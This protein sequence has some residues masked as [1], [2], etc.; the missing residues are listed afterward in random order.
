MT[1]ALRQATRDD[2]E[3]LSTLVAEYFRYDGIEFNATVESGIGELLA[4]PSLG[5][6]WF[7]EA[8]GDVAG[9]AVLTAAFDHEIGGRLGV[10]TDF[11]LSEPLRGKGLGPRFLELVLGKARERGYLAVE[12]VV[13]DDNVRAR[14]IYESAGFRSNPRRVGMMKLLE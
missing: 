12:L 8:K 13:M 14:T 5:Q 9:Y 6:A 10:M 2:R 1:L 11:F 4:D 3:A 7:L